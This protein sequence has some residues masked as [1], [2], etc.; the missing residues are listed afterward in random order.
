[1]P[2]VARTSREAFA[3]FQH[4]LN[5]TLNTVLTRY[6]LELEIFGKKQDAAFLNF[7]DPT[8]REKIAVPLPPSP[9][10]LYL[11]QVLR[12]VPEEK[13]FRLVTAQ[14]AYRIQRT[15]PISD[16]AESGLSIFLPA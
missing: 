4:H 10:F 14:Y 6:R 15:S 8:V 9:W 12:T 3:T 2:L 11:G 7:R 5:H 13:G 1:M 16:E